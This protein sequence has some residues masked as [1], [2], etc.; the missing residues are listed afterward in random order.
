MEIPG[1]ISAEIDSVMML[2]EGWDVRNV[3]VVLGLRPFTAKAEILPE[4]VIG[5]G[6][7]L[8]IQVS[9]GPHPN[10]RSARHA[11]A[12]GCPSDPAR[13][14]RRRCRQ[15]KT[16]PPLPVNIYPVQERQTYDIA[17]PLTKP[18][19]EHDIRKLSALRVDALD[20]IYKQE[21]LELQFREKLKLEFVTTQTEVHEADVTGGE[22]APT[23]ELLASVTNKT[24]AQAKLPTRFAELYPLVR[25]YVA[26]RCFGK[27]VD[28]EE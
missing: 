1:Q 20:A 21:D 22:L 11:Q 14:R 17:I 26:S 24:I 12:A 8:M 25:G 3:T 2:R 16:D 23:S 6:L 19:L 4:Q 28:L 15:R 27:S 5:R 13:S 9:S 18:S 7:R 10:T